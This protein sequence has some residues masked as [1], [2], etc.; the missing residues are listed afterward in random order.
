MGRHRVTRP[1]RA[2]FARSVVAHCKYEIEMRRAR[3]AK[4]IPALAAQARR[5]QPGILQYL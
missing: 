4:L 3:Q 1:D 5:R 2:N